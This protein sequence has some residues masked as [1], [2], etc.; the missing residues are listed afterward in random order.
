ML[1][2]RNGALN[3]AVGGQ[4]G[5]AA[6]IAPFPPM[7]SGGNGVA[8]RA[9]VRFPSPGNGARNGAANGAR[10]D[11]DEVIARLEEAGETLLCLPAGGYT[12]ALRTSTWTVLQEAAEAYGREGAGVRL[13]P[14][15]PSAA[16]ITR[17]D[18]VLGWL[19]L[20]PDDRYVL[21]RIVACRMLVSP[22]TGRHL[23][24]WRR[25]GTLL[26]ADHKA[27]QRWH[28]QGIALLVRGLEGADHSVQ[29]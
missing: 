20:I 4:P 8:G 11:A 6:P 13:R 23:Y 3:G 14:P 19:S 9:Q 10:L 26:G 5:P 1:N 29:A 28:G 16:K 27:V 17:M 24:P 15:V 22:T 12:T 7:K 2:D 25:L 18:Q 21:R